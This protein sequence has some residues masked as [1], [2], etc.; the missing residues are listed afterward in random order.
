MVTTGLLLALAGVAQAVTLSGIGSA[1]GVSIVE[2]S[3]SPRIRQVWQ[4]THL[5]GAA[6]NPGHGGF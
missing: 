1:I 5:A 2:R 6:G 4:D 3:W